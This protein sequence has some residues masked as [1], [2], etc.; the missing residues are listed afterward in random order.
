M[1]GMSAG[2]A[3]RALFEE[4]ARIGKALGSARRMEILD[5]LCQAER[6]V[7]VLAELTGM[8]VTS[9]SQ[10]LQLLRAAGLVAVR[11][12]GSRSLYRVSDPTVCELL[13]GLQRVARAR[14]GDADRLAREHLEGEDELEPVR[15][16]ELLA[17]L[18]RN[19]VVVVDLRPI[20]EYE[21]GHVPG[22]I[23]IPLEE[24]RARLNELPRDLEIVA[25]CRG[26][27]CVLAPQA[28]RVLREAGFR[29]RRLDGGLPEWRVAGYPVE[30]GA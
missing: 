5:L 23:P 20:E 7:E 29:A 1:L 15:R 11:K 16:E 19:E 27:F 28:L 8:G 18:R 9:T 26:P 6:S 13:Y 17:R 22:A 14:L 30:V 4:F 25:Y 21:A 24:L 12:E 10:H 2:T 3:K